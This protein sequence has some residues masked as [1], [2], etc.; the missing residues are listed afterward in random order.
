MRGIASELLGRD[1]DWVLRQG[2][3]EHALSEAIR[4]ETQLSRDELL[5]L[6]ESML[7][8]VSNLRIRTIENGEEKVSSALSATDSQ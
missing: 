5:V 3:P 2:I 4:S 6:G 7:D 1:C 8:L